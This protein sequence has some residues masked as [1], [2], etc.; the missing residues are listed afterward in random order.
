[1]FDLCS[2]VI[3]RPLHRSPRMPPILLALAAL[4]SVV[5]ALARMAIDRT[6]TP[7]AGAANLESLWP[8]WIT[9]L[10][11]WT[12]LTWLWR[13]E[14]GQRQA[15]SRR[16][17]VQAALFILA[18]ALIARSAVILTHTPT[19]SDDIHR[20][21]FD[22]RNIANGVNPYI[23]DPASRAGDEAETWAGESVIVSLMNNRELHTVYLP[24]SQLVFGLVGQLVPD[25]EADPV[26]V[27][28][29]FR[30]AFVLLELVAMLLA[31]GAL[32]HFGRSAWWLA[33]YAWHP[34]PLSE[35]AASGHQDIIGIV[36]IVA[37][38]L[39][40]TISPRRLFGPIVS[41]AIAALVKP[42]AIPIA[43]L[44]MRGRDLRRWLVWGFVGFLV[45]A[46]IAAPVLLA[47]DGAPLEHLRDTLDRFTWKW[48]HFGSVYEPVLKTLELIAPAGDGETRERLARKLCTGL[49]GLVI[50][51]VW[52]RGRDA[53]RDASI[54]F[55][56]M[57]LISPTAHPWYLLWA[58]VLFP[59]AP[60]RS[61]WIA[62]LTLPW[63]YAVLADPVTWQV[64]AWVMLLAY[65]PIYSLIVAD[66]VRAVRG[67]DGKKSRVR[68]RR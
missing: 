54:I 5:V 41:L 66:F 32:R 30:V 8:W 55:L 23:A 21:V 16:K 20:Y 68:S 60:V 64:D 7:E 49:L 47:Q 19:L 65:L 38:L 42:V 26:V 22:G 50:L 52:L 36:L 28:R 17:F 15:S 39:L 18:T 1:M 29:A 59:V 37:A 40:Y 33:L 61:V 3:I 9:S 12:A 43:A 25:D 2:W 57:V 51:G 13:V 58:F 11:A 14:T 31:L 62:S 56:A 63:G 45:T 67:D 53:W 24:V 48:A 10:L 27:G 4:A 46:A 44:M 6:P 35:I 34:L